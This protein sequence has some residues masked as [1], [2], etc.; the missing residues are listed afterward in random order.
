MAVKDG[1]AGLL[2]QDVGYDGLELRLG[3]VLHQL[4]IAK[5]ELMVAQ[6]DEVV[7]RCVQHGDGGFALVGGNVGGALAVVAGVHQDHGCTPGLIVSLDLGHLGKAQQ[8]AVGVVG[9]QND[10][11][12][13]Q[14]TGGRIN[15]LFRC[16]QNI[17]LHREG[18]AGSVVRCVGGELSVTAVVLQVH[19]LAV[20]LY[21]CALQIVGLLG[22]VNRGHNPVGVMPLGCVGQIHMGAACIGSQ[23]EFALR[24]GVAA[25]LVDGNR[26]YHRG[27][28][29]SNRVILHSGIHRSKVIITL[30]CGRNGRLAAGVVDDDLIT[31]LQLGGK[32]VLIGCRFLGE[33][34][35]HQGQD[36]GQRQ[37]QREKPFG[38]MLFHS[39]N[40]F[41]MIFTKSA[42]R[43]SVRN[44]RGASGA[45][46]CRSRRQQYTTKTRPIQ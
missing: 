10:R 38:E 21:R 16:V 12:A 43:C 3:H 19:R 31:V 35:G 17:E 36:H 29:I 6:S 40:S 13:A 34:H 30:D 26:P 46:A 18:I 22:T 7:A 41:F 32:D 39:S 33:G 37:K 28:R 42:E 11:L 25:I 4:G 2:Q 9:V 23:G 15:G 44:D 1:L 8:R 20:L 14:V 45:E 27:I 24:E 5:V